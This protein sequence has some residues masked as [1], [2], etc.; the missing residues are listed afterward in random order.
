V[1]VEAAKEGLEERRKTV[2]EVMFEVG[3]NDSKA[4]RD[5]FKKYTGISPLDYR[6][7]FGPSNIKMVK[8]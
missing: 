1:R 7:K 4:F 8:N 6:Q 5:V 3:Y 2:N